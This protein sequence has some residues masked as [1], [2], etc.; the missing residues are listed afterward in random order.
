[1]LN[2]LKIGTKLFIGFAVALA[3]LVAIAVMGTTRLSSLSE[4]LQQVVDDRN[5]KTAQAND[6][7][8][9]LNVIARSM[10]NM[11]LVKTPDD[12]KR[13]A[14]RIVEQ[15]KIIGERLDRFEV[16]FN[17]AKG[18]ELLKGLKDARAA[19]VPSQEKFIELASSG[20]RDEAIDFMLT[21]VRVQQNAYFKSV[22]DT[23]N[24]LTELTASEGKAALEAAEAAQKMMITLA[25]IA[26]LLSVIL[27]YVITRSITKPV[28]EVAE[29]ARKMAEG[30][31]NFKLESSAKDEVG[32]VVRAVASV[33]GAVQAMTADANLLAQAAVDGKLAT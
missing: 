8:D 18:K 21:T 1:M 26:V 28:G 31:F 19:Y 24:Y 7:I 6:I 13:E 4:N 14:A 11:L 15:R 20:R 9:A 23:V 22:L 27:A 10:R 16:T 17:T 29:A 2:N 33:Q 32:E 25:V 12:V 30:N 5:P 3:L